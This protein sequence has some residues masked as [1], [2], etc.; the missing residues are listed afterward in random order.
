[1]VTPKPGA[2]CELTSQTPQPLSGQSKQAAGRTFAF[3]VGDSCV[4]ALHAL[5]YLQVQPARTVTGIVSDI[6]PQL[7]VQSA[8]ICTRRACTG[9]TLP[10]TS[11]FQPF[12]T[13][14]EYLHPIGWLGQPLFLTLDPQSGA[15]LQNLT[16]LPLVRCH[17][18]L[19]SWWEA[20]PCHKAC[21]TL[22]VCSCEQ[23]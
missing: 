8:P 2:W 4:D 18:S 1:M 21:E 11:F 13:S 20:Q 15:M 3:W 7:P 23:V 22:H 5:L 16:W 17:H 19:R 6:A 14:K 9:L 10:T 12:G